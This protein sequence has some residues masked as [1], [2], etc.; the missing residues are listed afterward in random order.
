MALSAMPSCFLTTK[1]NSKLN[2]FREISVYGKENECKYVVIVNIRPSHGLGGQMPES[3]I[4]KGHASDQQ[5]EVCLRN[6][7]IN[8]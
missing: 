2:Y 6:S 5:Q 3:E 7:V 8:E 4:D 1:H